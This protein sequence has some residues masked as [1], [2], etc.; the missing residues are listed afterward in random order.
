MPTTS[1]N[2]L[3]S[4]SD[5]RRLG[6]SYCNSHLLRLEANGKFPKR[7][8]LTP[9]RVAWVEAE[10]LEYINRIVF[11]SS[12]LNADNGQVGEARDE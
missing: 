11:G 3:L 4:R 1:G 10:V 12:C 5:I 6:I 2:R 7:R 9:A 8:Y